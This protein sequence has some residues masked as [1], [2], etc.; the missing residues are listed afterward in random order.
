M[1]S[2]IN[3]VT[4]YLKANGF[5]GLWSEYGECGCSIADLMEC[6]SEGIDA[7]LPGYKVPCKG[8]V[9]DGDCEFH[10]GPKSCAVEGVYLGDCR[11]VGERGDCKYYHETLNQTTR[12]EI[13]PH[14]GLREEAAERG[15]YLRDRAKDEKA[16][17]DAQEKEAKA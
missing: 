4:E 17:A 13:C 9:C 2:V 1:K 12:W 5:D 3:I 14:G 7:C 16:E 6:E 10:I 11:E 15:D 8:G